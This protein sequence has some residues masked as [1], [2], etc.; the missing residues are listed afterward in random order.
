MP[1]ATK[2]KPHF[3]QRLRWAREQYEMS[4]QEFGDKL[5]FGRSY[6]NNLEAGRRDNP[7]DAFLVKL[8]SVFRVRLEWL[9]KGEG[10]PFDDVV[11][12]ERAARGEKLNFR[13]PSLEQQL[14]SMADLAR[15]LADKFS[16]EELRAQI[17]R[18][19]LHPS[20]PPDFKQAMSKALTEEIHSR[21]PKKK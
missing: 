4:L 5:G 11:L 18:I 7:S 20:Y 21:K 16:E 2:A 17:D 8:N 13:E 10:T 1:K 15:K 6:I 3:G 9:F 12:A 14:N 19:I